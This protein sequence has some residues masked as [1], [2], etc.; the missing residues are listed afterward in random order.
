M[1]EVFRSKDELL[2]M[3]ADNNTRDISEQDLRDMVISV[4]GG[5][6]S[7]I[8]R[9]GST[10]QATTSTPAKLVNWLSD[11]LNSDITSAFADGEITIAT[12]GIHLVMAD[13]C[14]SGSANDMFY[15]A[16]YIDSGSGYVSSGAHRLVSSPSSAGDIVSSSMHGYK[17][18]TAGTKI[19]LYVWSTTG[20][21]SF[22][23]KEGIFSVKKVY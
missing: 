6:G 5:F 9:D 11:G 17:N 4:L 18:L 1:A 23:I 16:T 2:T 19:C 15:L 7:I 13:I 8:V 20:G 10:A 3:F 12:D 14:F 22:T 21:T